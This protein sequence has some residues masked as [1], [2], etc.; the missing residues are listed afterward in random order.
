[1]S[2]PG[3]CF[4]SSLTSTKLFLFVVP[5]PESYSSVGF[6]GRKTV[7][8]RLQEDGRYSGLRGIFRLWLALCLGW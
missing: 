7:G 3:P 8:A 1:M 2:K 4:L 5:T 6:L